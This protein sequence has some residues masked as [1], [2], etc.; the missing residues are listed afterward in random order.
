MSDE[1][2]VSWRCY[3]ERTL[4]GWRT[5]F[6]APPQYFTIAEGEDGDD[7]AEAHCNG[8]RDMFVGALRR[9]GLHDPLIQRV[10]N[11]PQSTEPLSA[12]AVAALDE[13][14]KCKVAGPMPST[15]GFGGAAQSVELRRRGLQCGCW[16]CLEPF[17]N[18]PFD[19]PKRVFWMVVCPQ[20]GNKRCP[21]ASHHDNA[22]TGSNEPGQKGSVYE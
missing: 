4:G 15:P 7:E 11:A 2:I 10:L 6:A 18:L 21:R 16:E 8:M 13:Y 5:M 1:P 19:D 14:V 22:C 9:A 12:G 3:V 17:A 20:C